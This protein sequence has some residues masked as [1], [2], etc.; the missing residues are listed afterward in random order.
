MTWVFTLLLFF[1]T[2]VFLLWPPKM[3]DSPVLECRI[4]E[5]NDSKLSTMPLAQKLESIEKRM[6]CVRNRSRRLL[7]FC[8]LFCLN[9]LGFT[10]Q[11]SVFWQNQLMT[12]WVQDFLLPR[13]PNWTNSQRFIQVGWMNIHW[14][15]FL[16]PFHFFSQ[17]QCQDTPQC[18]SLLLQHQLVVSH[19]RQRPV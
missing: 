3:V 7:L 8:S 18:V 1:S 12:F 14:N 19:V 6:C 16:M 13:S 5:K 9:Q 11:S 15:L 2:F 17:I 4:C 10:L